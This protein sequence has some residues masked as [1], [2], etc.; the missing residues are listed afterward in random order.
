MNI[1]NIGVKVANPRRLYMR[2][3]VTAQ[4]VSHFFL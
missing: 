3:P 1:G 2:P 4:L